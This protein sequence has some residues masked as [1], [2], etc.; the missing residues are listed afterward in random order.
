MAPPAESFYTI[1]DLLL[2]WPWEGPKSPALVLVQQDANVWV[3][4][5]ELF[6]PDQLNKFR[7]YD[8]G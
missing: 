2:S 7:A 1:P 8:F 6:K 4:S 5:L 3:E